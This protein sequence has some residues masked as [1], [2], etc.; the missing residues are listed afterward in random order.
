M[1]AFQKSL[2]NKLE[3][4]YGINATTINRDLLPEQGP[5]SFVSNSGSYVFGAALSALPVWPI[6]NSDGTYFKPNGGANPV[7]YL[8]E[9][10]S[11]QQENLY[12]VSVTANYKI[13]NSLTVG[14]LGAVTEGNNVYDFFYP[15]L[16]NTNEQ[17]TASK[18]N[19][20]KQNYSGDI[21]A[22]WH[23]SFGKH[24]IDLTGV[25]EYN[26]FVN[27]GFSVL[28]KGFLLPGLVNNN[29]GAANTVQTDGIN[30]Y[31][32]EVK[33]I[34][35]LGRLVYNYDERYLLTANIRADGSS[36][37]GPNNAWGYFPSFALG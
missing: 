14:A 6:Y 30:S 11:K 13:I 33:L 31:K 23:Q 1:T 19:Q 16:E 2:N 3:I 35:Y 21:H 28:A 29:L 32:N 36:K 18:S 17:S 9:T 4:R 8:N 15:G 22:N 10:T 20:N 34:S 5:G 12:Q 37:F 26:K 7:R 27:D 25:Y 24:T